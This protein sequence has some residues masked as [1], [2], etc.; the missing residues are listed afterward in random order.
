MP[1]KCHVFSPLSSPI[2]SF[3]D[4]LENCDIAGSRALLS[5]H[6]ETESWL[7]S[8]LQSSAVFCV[9]LH[10]HQHKCILLVVLDDFRDGFKS[11]K[12]N[13]QGGDFNKKES[14]SVE[15][16]INVTVH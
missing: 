3:P 13:K 7:Y 4:V 10:V 1:A 12:E 6:S 11:L 14:K 8:M 15:T 16:R 9:A 5:H 2:G